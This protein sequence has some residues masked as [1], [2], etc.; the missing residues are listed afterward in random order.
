MRRRT[1]AQNARKDDL[2]NHDQTTHASTGRIAGGATETATV[3]GNGYHVRV[4][5]PIGPLLHQS[6]QLVDRMYAARRLMVAT[7]AVHRPPAERTD[8]CCLSG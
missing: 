8:P 4:V 7:H 2:H 1:H 5:P 6:R 3:T